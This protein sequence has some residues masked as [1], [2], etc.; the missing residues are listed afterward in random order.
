MEREGP[1]L[2]RKLQKYAVKRSSYI[3]QFCTISSRSSNIQGT[4][5]IST[6]T[7]VRSLPE[8]IDIIAVVLNLNPLYVTVLHCK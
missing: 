4:T 7:I 1:E 6:L 5:R 8:L 3:E 2:Q